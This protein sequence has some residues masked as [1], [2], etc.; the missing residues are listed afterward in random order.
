M[1]IIDASGEYFKFHW[2]PKQA[3]NVNTGE[4]KKYEIVN[5][6]DVEWYKIFD[7]IIENKG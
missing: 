3:K 2:F 5:V 4:I 1:K 7:F 6:H